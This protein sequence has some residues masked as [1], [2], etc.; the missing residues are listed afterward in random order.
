MGI[1]GECCIAVVDFSS[2][3]ASSVVS[4]DG[5]SSLAPGRARS[6]GTSSIADS[7]LVTGS[8]IV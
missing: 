4:R 2:R 7:D 6:D 5:L 8:M 1:V 3:R